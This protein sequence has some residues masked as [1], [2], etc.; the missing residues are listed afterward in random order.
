MLATVNA[1]RDRKVTFG[2]SR[3]MTT[4]VGVGVVIVLIEVSRKPAASASRLPKSRARS[5]ENFTAAESTGVP[6]WNFT[7]GRSSNVYVVPSAETWDRSPLPG[8][9]LDCYRAPAQ[10]RRAGP[11]SRGEP[12]SRGQATGNRGAIRN[13]LRRSFA[14]G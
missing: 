5:S 8:C 3:V 12:A 11:P 13:R 2:L 6:S 9:G 4:D 10:S 7:P 1:R 14:L